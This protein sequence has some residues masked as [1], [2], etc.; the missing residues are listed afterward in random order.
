M[1][2]LTFNANIFRT[3]KLKK[4]MKKVLFGLAIAAVSTSGLHAQ[5]VLSGNI[6]ANKTLDEPCYILR[7]CVYVKSGATLTINPGTVI[8]GDTTAGLKGA[9]I[10]ERGAKINADGSTAPIVFTSLAPAGSRKPGDWGGIIL[11]GYGT[12][13]QPGDTFLVE[14]PCTPVIAGGTNANDNSGVF[15]YV[16]IDYAGVA[17]T[18]N[19]EI[20]SLTMAA[21]G[22]GT[23][24]DHVQVSYANDDAFEWFGGNV[25]TKYLIS[26]NTRD[27]DFD[28]DFGFSGKS[29]FGLALRKDTAQHDIS[30]SNGIESDNMGT[31][32]YQSPAG[33]PETRPVFSNFTIF[34]P[35]YC[36]PGMTVSSQFQNGALIRR[37][38]AHSVYN[39]VIAGWPLNGL[40]INDTATMNNTALL[41]SGALNFSYNTLAGNT[42]N[43]NNT[44]ATWVGCDASMTAWANGPAAP[45]PGVDCYQ[46]GN[47]PLSG[48]ISGYSSSICNNACTGT[49]PT[50]T[51]ATGTGNL[52]APQ[53]DDIADLSTGFDV[54]NY[55]GAFGATDWTAGWTV[56]CPQSATYSECDA[57]PR[58]A[59]GQ[60]QST[61]QL[62]PNPS[63]NNTTAVFM[64]GVTG[65]A[66]ISILDKVSG[67]ALRV[68][69]ADITR[70]GEQRVALNVSGLQVGVYVVRVTTAEGVLTQQLMVK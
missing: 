44:P 6:T 1:T 49:G 65:K 53:F 51:Y 36:N 32:P 40:F 24:I 67:Q 30:G 61:L 13:N 57:A 59:A 28:T 47:N 27:D 3:T 16:R 9:L 25:N 15:R 45:I 68:V 22:N 11:A 19:D 8:K 39:S 33:R 64:A 17:R 62:V 23:T 20:N 70:T 43:Y 46:F 5:T 2:P 41:T 35:L 37:N 21:V 52:G 69:T 26:Y 14:G 48:L 18:V 55:R 63:S 56:W 38:S 7:G 4:K 60:V 31:A 12:N 58:A 29:Q 10:I 50:F 54:V 42:T 34:G 66:T